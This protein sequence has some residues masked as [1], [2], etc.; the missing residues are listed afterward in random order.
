MVIIY[1]KTS[2]L[3]HVNIRRKVK[4]DV[5]VSMNNLKY[6]IIETKSSSVE[7]LDR[8]EES[9]LFLVSGESERSGDQVTRRVEAVLDF[10][11][12]QGRMP[13]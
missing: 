7:A 2:H 1:I 9:K 4:V 11:L 13:T 5:G 8:R 3:I 12:A 6:A 10:E